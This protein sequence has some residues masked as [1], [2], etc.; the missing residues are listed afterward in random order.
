MESEKEITR[1]IRRFLKEHSV[2]HWK[3]LQGLGSMMD[4]SDI[5]GVK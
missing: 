5:I 2:F 3:P 1:G 4:V